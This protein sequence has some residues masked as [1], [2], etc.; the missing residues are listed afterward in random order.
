MATRTERARVAEGPRATYVLPMRRL[1][2]VA[3]GVLCAACGGDTPQ[4][5]ASRAAPPTELPG[6]WSVIAFRAGSDIAYVSYDMT[7][8]ADT[9]GWTV[10]FPGRDPMAVR[11]LSASRDSI[12][13]VLGPYPSAVRTGATVTAET[14]GRVVGDRIEG[15]FI[16]RYDRGPDPEVRGRFEGRRKSGSSGPQP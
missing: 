11:V 14:I 7:A 15:R 1:A 9:S 8:T 4:V 16:A 10:T 2:F 13:V 12:D 5:Q 6:A 3:L